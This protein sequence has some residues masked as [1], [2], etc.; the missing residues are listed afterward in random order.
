MEIV[1]DGVR[2][3]PVI[4]TESSY[5]IVRSSKAGVFAGEIVERIGSEVHMRNARRIWYWDGASSLSQL[6]VD[7]PSRPENCKFPVAVPSVILL[8]VCEILAVT[9]VA[10][11][12]IDAVPIW[13]Q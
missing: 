3:A 2:Y 8:D 9:A 1:I 7:G 12:R 6:A 10:R 13:E 11:I 4:E 5:H